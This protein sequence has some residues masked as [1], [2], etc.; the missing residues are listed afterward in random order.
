MRSPGVVAKGVAIAVV[1]A[2]VSCS[3]CGYER[4][5]LCPHD[6]V[7]PQIQRDIE[8]TLAKLAKARNVL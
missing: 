6:L 1:T 4:L 2:A 3:P 5:E 8:P 7:N